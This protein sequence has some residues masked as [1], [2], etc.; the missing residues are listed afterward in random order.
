M[1]RP[2]LRHFHIYLRSVV[3]TVFSVGR[4][5]DER[6]RS[7]LALAQQAQALGAARRARTQLAAAHERERAALRERARTLQRRL[8]ALDSEYSAQL[9]ALRAAYQSAV[10]ADTH[11]DGL[12]ARYQQEIEQLRALCEKGLLAMEASHRRI[13]RE[14]EEKH[15]AERDQLRLDKE[16]ALAEETRATLA[17]L[18]AMRKAHESEVRREVD[19]F[20]A[21]F[22]SRGAHTADLSQLSTRHQ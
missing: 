18:D 15:R 12:R 16:Q 20:K 4:L 2:F 17:A 8:A 13:V 3:V 19:K 7:E 5:K 14:M 6:T 9:E 22:L 10:A 1:R 21:E 11:G